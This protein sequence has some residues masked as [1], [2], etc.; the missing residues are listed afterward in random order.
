MLSVSIPP[1]SSSF[2]SSFTN[3]LNFTSP[4][5]T[6]HFLG[7]LSYFLARSLFQGSNF[8]KYCVGLLRGKQHYTLCVCI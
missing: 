6:Y 2:Y 4:D 3:G 7:A 5:I 1:A 8:V